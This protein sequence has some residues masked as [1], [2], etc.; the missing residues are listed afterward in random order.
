MQTSRNNILSVDVELLLELGISLE[1]Y[2]VLQCLNNKNNTLLVNYITKC[3]L[4]KKEHFFKLRDKEYITLSNPDNITLDGLRLTSKGLSLFTTDTSKIEPLSKYFDE[5]RDN[6]PKI[7][8]SENGVPRRLHGDL[9]RCRK[10]YSKILL[11]NSNSIN[12]DLHNQILKAI[13]KQVAEYTKGK[14]LQYMYNL[15]TYLQQKNYIEYI[16]DLDNKL[17]PEKDNKTV[18]GAD[19]F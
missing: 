8:P 14:R 10:L 11:E 19:T 15:A 18:L 9:P 12:I 17:E 2:F 13:N 7:V 6:Y 16:E 3:G 1:S 4:F 5:L